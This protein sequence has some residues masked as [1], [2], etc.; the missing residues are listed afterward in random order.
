MLY[1][2]DMQGKMSNFLRWFRIDLNTIL[3]GKGE[4]EHRLHRRDIWER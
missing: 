3:I 4:E 1:M 2:G